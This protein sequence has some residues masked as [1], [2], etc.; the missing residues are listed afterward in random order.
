MGSE[1]ATVYRRVRFP[2]I[3]AFAREHGY[4]YTSVYKHL[5]GKMPS[6]RMA[7]RWAEWNARRRKEEA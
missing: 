2:G 5:V 3:C 6:K 1:K 7:T 4:N